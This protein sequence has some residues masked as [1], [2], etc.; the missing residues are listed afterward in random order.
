MWNLEGTFGSKTN[1]QLSPVCDFAI[2]L[3]ILCQKRKCFELK[4]SCSKNTI[5]RK[6]AIKAANFMIG[7][8]VN[9]IGS[10]FVIC[11]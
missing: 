6:H 2:W 8:R 1:F 4:T 5:Y 7:F 3:R 10:L 9:L 11:V